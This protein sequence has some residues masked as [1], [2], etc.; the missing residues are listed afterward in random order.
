MSASPGPLSTT[1]C[2]VIDSETTGPPDHGVLQVAALW[3]DVAIAEATSLHAVRQSEHALLC[4]WCD[5]GIVST[6][7]AMAVHHILPDRVQGYPPWSAEHLLPGAYLIGHHIDYDTAALGAMDH[8]RICTLALSRR[9]WPDAPDHKLGTLC[10]AVT[11]TEQ[12]AAVRGLLIAAHDART[13]VLACAYLLG[14]ILRRFRSDGAPVRSAR[15][16]WE[17]SE[18]ARVPTT[19]PFGK[20]RGTALI[21]LPPDYVRWLLQLPDLDPYLRTALETL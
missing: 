8:P 17:R 13:D 12:W 15:D 7:A 9:L 4:W 1:E 14:V 21:D 10:Y 11:P 3:C 6:P 5:P 18:Q 20:H 2:Y 16:L 19:M